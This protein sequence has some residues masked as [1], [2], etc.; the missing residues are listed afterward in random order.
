MVEPISMTCSW[1]ISCCEDGNDRAPRRVSESSISYF[2]YTPFIPVKRAYKKITSS[3]QN[4]VWG[5]V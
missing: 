1:F 5:V 2:S 3:P 4:K